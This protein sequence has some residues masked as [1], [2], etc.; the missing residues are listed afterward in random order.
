MVS[1]VKVSKIKGKRY[2]I[3]TG[4]NVVVLSII[5]VAGLVLLLRWNPEKQAN[6]SEPNT[7]VLYC[8][9]GIKP[10]VEAAAKKYEEEYG[11]SIQLQYGGSGTLLSNIKV[12]KRGDLYLAADDSYLEIARG[13][14]LA[15]EGIPL[16]KMVP[17]IAVQKGNPKKIESLDD[18]W[19]ED[20]RVVLANPDA[21]AIG[22]ITRKLLE[23]LG[24]WESLKI[25][26]KVF[27][28]TV[29]DQANDV[30][31]GTMDAAII[32]DAVANQYPELEIIRVP[33]FAQV[34]QLISIGVLHSSK[35][36]TAALRFARYLGAPNKGLR[37]FARLG[38][39]P[40]DGDVW[41]EHP[42]I[43][44]FS[45]GVNRLAIQES[46]REFEEREGVTVLTSYNGCGILVGQ[47]KAGQRPDAYFACDVS[48][49]TEVQDLF[50]D[51]MDIAATNMVIVAAKDNPLGLNTLEDLTREGLKLGVANAKQSALGALTERLLIEAGLLDGVMVNVKSQTPTAD[52]LVNQMRTGSLDAV[53]V[54]EANTPMVRGKLEVIP[55]EH[56]MANA[57]QPIA[58]GKDSKYKY[59]VGRLLDKIRSDESKKRFEWAG[60]RW[61]VDK[62]EG[63]S[64]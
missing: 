11:V 19:R 56:A 16:A 30:K 54:Y 31:L 22:K 62:P 40:I 13:E 5:A 45:G 59:L 42:N 43:A 26:T 15:A 44:L 8:A 7:L 34:E 64:Y 36:P 57:R 32:W 21:A 51:S 6:A 55:I 29:N 18:L 24:K 2:A 49:M 53:I 23:K 60:F 47:M 25:K 63:Q 33:E 48:F 61:Q 4:R 35:R 28:P 38:Y 14:G 1:K 37:D 46:I 58:I 10:P 3:S 17:I 27:K 50:L 52:L 12:A 9:A 20:V 39:E 41:E